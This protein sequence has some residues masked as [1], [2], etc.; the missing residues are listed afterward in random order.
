MFSRD[1]DTQELVKSTQWFSMQLRPKRI[2]ARREGFD[3]LRRIKDLFLHLRYYKVLIK[4]EGR[5]SS[6]GES[7]FGGANLLRRRFD[8]S[9]RFPA[10]RGF[11]FLRIP[12]RIHFA[13]PPRI[14]I[15]DYP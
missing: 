14:A 11:P 4:G 8:D 6:A 9:T 7:R 13:N 1:M 5:E 3:R 2:K 15:T 12:S 10:N